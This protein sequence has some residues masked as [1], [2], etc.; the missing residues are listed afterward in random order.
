M[1]I[2]E[3][4]FYLA[5]KFRFK[6]FEC[7]CQVDRLH[8]TICVIFLCIGCIPGVFVTGIDAGEQCLDTGTDFYAV[9][10]IGIDADLDQGRFDHVG[11][12]A[13]P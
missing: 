1:F 9:G 13:A 11:N 12:S 7:R 10:A 4:K 8:Y 3:N 6:G 2:I 5:G